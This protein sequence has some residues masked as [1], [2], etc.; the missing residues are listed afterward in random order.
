MQRKQ[1]R[2]QTCA[3]Q[4]DP[5]IANLERFAVDLCKFQ[6]LGRM[7]AVLINLPKDTRLLDSRG[8]M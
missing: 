5:K 7:K 3:W 6:G 8:G 2:V 4:I 1:T